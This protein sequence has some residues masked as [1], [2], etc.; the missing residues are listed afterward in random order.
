ME[1][2]EADPVFFRK[3]AE[4]NDL[5]VQ[6]LATDADLDILKTLDLPAILTFY[7]PNHAWPKYLTLAEIDADTVYLDAGDQGGLST[8]NQKDLL[9]FWSGEAYI[10]WKNFLAL[11]NIIYADSETKS[12]ITLKK[13]LTDL[14]YTVD[15]SSSKY[16]AKTIQSIINIQ[17]ENGLEVDGMV[18][19]FTKIMLYNEKG[20]F[21]KPSL[22]KKT[23]TMT[24]NGR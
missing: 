3:A 4:E 1:T 9:R 24:E 18:G 21:I 15:L 7:L 16:D 11:D 20:D 22:V 5:L 19:P 10:L 2:I 14:D 8:V 12:V 23:K 6:P 13:L 17:Q